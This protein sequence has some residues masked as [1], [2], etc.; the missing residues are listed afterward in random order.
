MEVSRNIVIPKLC[1]PPDARESPTKDELIKILTF[2]G[3]FGNAKQE[4]NLHLRSHPGCSF[5]NHQGWV[6]DVM[7]LAQ[8]FAEEL[9]EAATAGKVQKNF[10]VGGVFPFVQFLVTNC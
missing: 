8:E 6:G 1:L 5:H 9:L 7:S 3:E 10:E 4:N 2:S